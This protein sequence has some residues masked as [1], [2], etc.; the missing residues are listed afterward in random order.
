MEQ[1]Q[2]IPV[3]WTKAIDLMF[4]GKSAEKVKLNRK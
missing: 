3:N 4:D 1:Q 2:T